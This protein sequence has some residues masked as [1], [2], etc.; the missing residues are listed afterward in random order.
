MCKKELECLAEPKPTKLSKISGLYQKDT[1]ANKKRLQLA[2]D[3]IVYIQKR[4]IEFG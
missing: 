2:Q 3:G 4:V 1:R